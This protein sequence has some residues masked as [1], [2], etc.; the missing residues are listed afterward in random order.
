MNLPQQSIKKTY[1]IL[2]FVALF[3]LG[4]FIVWA[5]A[6]SAPAAAPDL[7]A[8]SD[9]GSSSTDNITTDDTPTLDFECTAITNSIQLY[10]AY[11]D[12]EAFSGT[13]IPVDSPV[14]CGL[15]GTRSITYDFTSLPDGSTWVVDFKYTEL[16]A[17]AEESGRSP[18]LRFTLDK[19]NPDQAAIDTPIEGNSVIDDTEEADVLVTGTAEADA[20]VT[21]SVGDNVNA[22]IIQNVTVNGSGI[23]TLS[24]N[25]FDVSGLNDGTLYI[26]AY[27]TDAAGNQGATF[28][29]PVTHTT[30]DTSPPTPSFAFDIDPG[31]DTGRFNNDSITNLATITGAYDCTEIGA[32]VV[33]YASIN[34]SSYIRSVI[35]TCGVVGSQSFLATNV[36]E[37]SHDAYYTIDNGTESG[38]SPNIYAIYDYTTPSAPAVATPVEDDNYINAAED[39]AVVLTGTSEADARVVITFTDDMAATV[40]AT[41]VASDQGQWSLLGGTEADLSGLSEGLIT[42]TATQEDL[43]GNIS[44][45]SSAVTA[46][47]D[48]T[49]PNSPT[50]L[51]PTHG[52]HSGLTAYAYGVC[53]E[54]DTIS[55]SNSNLA[56]DPT[57]G[58]C[59]SSSRFDIEY[60]FNGVATAADQDVQIYATDPAGN[61]STITTIQDVEVNNVLGAGS[62]IE[63]QGADLDGDGANGLCDFSE[64]TYNANNNNALTYTDCAAGSGDDIIVF[65]VGGGG[66][67]TLV[68]DAGTI[69]VESTTIVDGTSQPGGAT[70]GDSGDEDL[71][72]RNLLISMDLGGAG[73]GQVNIA[74]GDYSVLRGLNIYNAGDTGT[75]FTVSTAD[76][77]KIECNHMG[78]NLAGTAATGENEYVLRVVDFTGDPADNTTVGGP[79][80]NDAN[81]VASSDDSAID[82]TGVSNL[83]IQNNRVG[84]SASGNTTI[85]V[86]G[87]LATDGIDICPSTGVSNTGV[88]I[89]DNI[90]AG[91]TNQI[92]FS[93]CSGTNASLTDVVIQGNHLGVDRLGT[94]VLYAAARGGIGFGTSDAIDNAYSGIVIGGDTAAERNVIGGIQGTNSAAISFA[95]QSSPSYIENITIQ[96]NYIGIG[97][98]GSTL[99]P[100]GNTGASG[101]LGQIYF[102]NAAQ[103][104][105]IGGSN[106]GEGNV[107]AGNRN[108]GSLFGPITVWGQTDPIEDVTIKGNIIGTDPAQTTN[109]GNDNSSAISL[110]NVNSAT[111]GGPGEN[112]GN[113]IVGH[114]T[115]GAGPFGIAADGIFLG[116]VDS[117]T[118]QGNKIGVTDNGTIMPNTSGI[119]AAAWTGAI[120]NA[121]I[122]GTGD[123]EGNTIKGSTYF[124]LGLA[125]VTHTVDNVTILGNN[126]D[127]GHG[128]ST[129]SID[130]AE[131]GPSFGPTT[132]DTDDAD[133]LA[134]G[135]NELM[136]RPVIRSA[137]DNGDN[138]ATVNF[139]LDLPTT[140]A[141]RV[142]FF[143]AADTGEI[144]AT[145]YLDFE[146]VEHV[147]GSGSTSYSLPISTSNVATLTALTA[148]VT[149]LDD[150][151]DGYGSTSELSSRFSNITES[152]NP[153]TPGG[154]G[155]EGGGT[156]DDEDEL[157]C[158]LYAPQGNEITEPGTDVEL[159]W[160]ILNQDNNVVAGDVVGTLKKKGALTSMYKL[161]NDDQQGLYLVSPERTTTYVLKDVQA[162][163]TPGDAEC[164]ITIT[165]TDPVTVIPGCTEKGAP[166]YN[167]NATVDNGSCTVPPTEDDILGCTDPQADN[168]NTTATY[169]DGSCEYPENL[170]GGCTDPFASNFSD[171]ADYDDGSCSYTDN[172]DGENGTG[173]E[174]GE[175]GR[176]NGGALAFSANLSDAERRA[177]QI[178]AT[179]AVAA[180][181]PTLLP[182]LWN[183]L[184]GFLGFR[185]KQRPWGTV[186]NAQ[187][188][189]PL[190]PAYVTLMNESGEEVASA[191][192]DPDGRYGFVVDPGTYTLKAAK[193]HFTFPSTTMQGKTKD[194][195]Y[196]DLY[197][198]EPI[199]ITERG[200]VIT[201]NIPMDPMGDDWNEAAKASMGQSVFNFFNKHDRIILRIINSLF[202]DYLYCNKST[203]CE[204]VC[205]VAMMPIYNHV[206]STHFH[207]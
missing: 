148:T 121:T 204:H 119:L 93:G 46:T 71:D 107:I 72:T 155:E 173:S 147:A 38:P 167:P 62:V 69:P 21:V 16:N 83:L 177:L 89:K 118:V 110:V 7:Q 156:N 152:D 140:G 190:D 188:K 136:N 5:A 142:E 86:S 134:D 4:T 55:V 61:V 63:V 28:T 129:T 15:V 106:P 124:G 137:V 13:F 2:L 123:G 206:S 185:R 92:T 22:T 99:V 169:N 10:I 105:L 57:T 108:R 31:S 51:Y 50:V 200:E 160:E 52:G 18:A 32:D 174:E 114:D 191:I 196:T 9:S 158:N 101:G 170:V 82:T 165:V 58:V 131:T 207:N 8:A 39:E 75:L 186:Y 79:D 132:N 94:T 183:L 96:G 179:I 90:I 168:F 87:S 40:N 73:A 130:L 128:F 19:E 111:I 205:M 65:N 24:G 100:N 14:A 141:Y 17:G 199:T 59:N 30:V 26:S 56:T 203:F 47:L 102:Y 77:T 116:A 149:E 33:S 36:T 202:W 37:G 126:I 84:V 45:S 29:Q 43:A 145:T 78:T 189:Q 12:P 68:A 35:G 115:V 171:S 193:T 175:G 34:G 91:F 3:L 48:Q 172:P 80:V 187:T 42:I 41:V 6:P 98:D 125:P 88:P 103:N 157:T 113:V 154:G 139:D 181:L 178:I 23:W 198:G 138:T 67:Q 161:A 194:E 97:A 25:E 104:V 163:F 49:A 176:G 151:S 133:V 184:L 122:G 166:N 201:K 135:A 76:N 85:P 11:I 195:L 81:V 197:F 44:A 153:A 95:N 164:E 60:T 1:A 180:T 74:D 192:T 146:L 109:I 162:Q 150:S 144:D 182:R 27:A 143:D 127:H 20:T 53:V 66:A 120:D 112:E 54:G 159:R 117:F 70:C 64:A